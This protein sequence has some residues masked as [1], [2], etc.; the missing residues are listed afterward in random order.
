MLSW[1]EATWQAVQR[2]KQE[3]GECLFVGGVTLPLALADLVACQATFAVLIRR[4][5]L[6]L[7][8]LRLRQAM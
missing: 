2:L 6:A 7:V 4:R 8:G 3:P 5:S 1:C